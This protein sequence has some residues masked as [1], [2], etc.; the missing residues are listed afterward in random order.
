MGSSLPTTPPYMI[1]V[2]V[3]VSLSV[4]GLFAAL[5]YIFCS[6]RYRLNWFE[7]TL[8]EE[9]K[10]AAA[11]GSGLHVRGG[12]AA[13][14]VTIAGRGGRVVRICCS[15]RGRRSS[16][17]SD[18]D[19]DEEEEEEEE[20]KEKRKEKPGG[21]R[22][23][24]KSGGGG[25]A[26]S[27]S[28][29]TSATAKAATAAAVASSF[30]AGE[31]TV[32][33]T[34][35]VASGDGVVA[36]TAAGPSP[37]LSPSSGPRTTAPRGSHRLVKQVRSASPWV[38]T[39]AGS[40]RTGAGGKGGR[41]ESSSSH[42]SHLSSSAVGPRSPCLLVPHSFGQSFADP[43]SSSTS[44]SLAA[45]S[46]PA[47][48]I[49][50]VVAPEVAK[51]V[52]GSPSSPS[53]PYEG[54]S[55]AV[56]QTTTWRI[57]QT[58]QQPKLPPPKSSSSPASSST[59]QPTTSTESEAGSDLSQWLK[60]LA[61][62]CMAGVAGRGLLGRS[63]TTTSATASAAAATATASTSSF[64]SSSSSGSSALTSGVRGG[65]EWLQSMRKMG[66]SPSSPVADASEKFWVPPAVLER[67]RAQSLIPAL[68]R[69]GSD[70]VMS[71]GQATPASIPPLRELSFSFSN[72]KVPG[73]AS[74]SDGLP[75][76][77]PAGYVPRRRA[78]MHDAIDYTKIDARLYDKKLVRQASV[79]SIEEENLGSINF[80][81]E[82]NVETSILTVYVIQARNLVPR[83]F[84]GTADPYVRVSLL[85]DQRSASAQSK[86]HRKT[87]NPLFQEE[88]IF[89]LSDS[90][91]ERAVLEIL[92]YDYDQFSR[93]ECIGYVHV[94]LKTVD[95]SE[96]VELWKGILPYEKDN[97]RDRDVGDVMF[98]LSYLPSAERLT[99]VV[100]KARNLR[101]PEGGR[102]TI[103]AHTRVTVMSGNK[104]M[105]KKKTA[106]VHNSINPVWNEALVF[107]LPRD[108]LDSI[109][110]EVSVFHDNKLGNDERIGKVR[111]SRDSCGEEKAHWQD[112]VR[113]KMAVAR[114]HKLS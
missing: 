67:K 70:E 76:T 29:P 90:Q 98:S 93:D 26:P 95:L 21:G 56:P 3:A 114:W 47:S 86:I 50:V 54:L 19:E 102:E 55:F 14:G 91:M 83:D 53:A 113:E 4:V 69:Q 8:L 87:V 1:A 59:I 13:S 82:H 111:L 6:R 15:S 80:T 92:V 5:V 74:G 75:S 45:A 94:P 96:R 65:A 46:S 77:P 58:P 79:K 99:V 2:Y 7:R 61:A 101:H 43:T 51:D 48:S 57:Q 108:H 68:S 64:S 71:S 89:E 100:V 22:Q 109:A 97:D 35:V 78:S 106:T 103:D 32:R 72:E 49:I 52:S 30:H 27:T 24:R 112:L 38:A 73:Q 11:V 107:N 40:S 9:H 36:A 66:S 31:P 33:C 62:R 84:S 10:G 85:P 20:E 25:G 88:F 104:K 18:R 81:L 105:K 17:D 37:S 16:D 34:R 28:P 41:L 23:E 60:Q 110:L 63:A 12:G 44:S 39:P 42:S